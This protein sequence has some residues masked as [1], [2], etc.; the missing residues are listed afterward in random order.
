MALAIGNV[1]D[2]SALRTR[3]EFTLDR[4]GRSMVERIS[5]VVKNA[6]PSAVTVRIG[7]SL[8]RWSAWEMVSSSLPFEKRNAQSVS[9]DVPVPAGGETTLTY[10]VRYRWAPDV[11]IP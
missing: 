8:P 1:F 11:K 2:L 3:E 6:K 10:T 4:D 5:V 7:E 9:F